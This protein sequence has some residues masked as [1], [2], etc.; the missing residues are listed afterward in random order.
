MR[1]HLGVFNVSSDLQFAR[2]ILLLDDFEGTLNWKV[3]HSNANASGV[4]HADA[5]FMGSQGMKLDT[6]ATGTADGDWVM[7]TKGV[8][9]PSND[10]LV[11]RFRVALNQIADCEMVSIFPEVRDASD[12]MHARVNWHPGDGTVQYLD[13]AGS[14]QDLGT[15]G[16]TIDAD[17]FAEMELVLD[18][19]QHQYISFALNGEE[20]PMDGIAYQ[21]V[22]NDTDRLILMRIYVECTAAGNAVAYVDSFYAGQFLYI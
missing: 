2:G 12:Q 6:G 13:S 18:L 10:L 20:T 1:D 9:W 15:Y 3:T 8:G 5:A 4:V 16:W 14:L 7:A 21:D 11:M 17:T 22:G 19:A